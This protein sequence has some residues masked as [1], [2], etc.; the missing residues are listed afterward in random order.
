MDPRLWSEKATKAHEDAAAP[1]QTQPVPVEQRERVIHIRAYGSGMWG[2]SFIDRDGWHRG[3]DISTQR[4]IRYRDDGW[5][6]DDP[7]HLLD[8]YGPAAL[9]E[10][11]VSIAAL[12]ADSAGY[13][14]YPS[15]RDGAGIVVAEL[16][17]S[18]D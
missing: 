16:E 4:L 6:L 17:D 14:A 3:W 7:L 10:E 18:D 2:V 1:R 8:L 5:A 13:P 15:G 11:F 12:D 9:R